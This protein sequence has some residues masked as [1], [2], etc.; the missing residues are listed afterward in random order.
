[1]PNIKEMIA[2]MGLVAQKKKQTDSSIES[3]DK[4]L[5]STGISTLN[6]TDN[7]NCLPHS[8]AS[9]IIDEKE[10]FQQPKLNI[11]GARIPES[12]LS[13]Q[14]SNTDSLFLDKG[15]IART[16]TPANS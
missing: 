2:R 13:D 9:Q 7:F 4:V 3:K 14:N 8:G 1:M 10:C 11:R 16:R 6:S 12:H 15:S 5:T